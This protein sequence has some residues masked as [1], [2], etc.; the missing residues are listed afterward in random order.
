MNRGLAAALLLC[1][2][3]GEGPAAMSLCWGLG[4]V[5]PG[6][7]TAAC[8]PLRCL[9]PVPRAVSRSVRTRCGTFAGVSGPLFISPGV[10]ALLTCPLQAPFVPQCSVSPLKKDGSLEAVQAAA[11][12]PRR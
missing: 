10:M 4:A 3:K 5:K 1:Q 2:N 6:A 9:S 12:R 7:R 11:Q 8:G